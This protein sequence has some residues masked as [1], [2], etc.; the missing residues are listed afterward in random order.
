MEKSP[1]FKVHDRDKALAVIPS[2]GFLLHRKWVGTTPMHLDSRIIS[3]RIMYRDLLIEF[4]T[5]RCIDVFF[6]G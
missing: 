1:D 6:P 2:D 4:L 3:P 5:C